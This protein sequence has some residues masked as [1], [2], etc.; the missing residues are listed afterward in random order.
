M[1]IGIG[2]INKE[3]EW[4]LSKVA[5]LFKYE[6]T[7]ELE[8]EFLK[9]SLITIIVYL[10][11][12][13]L[14][15]TSKQFK[16]HSNNIKRKENNELRERNGNETHGWRGKEKTHSFLS[17]L[18]A[19]ESQKFLPNISIIF[20]STLG[21]KSSEPSTPNSFKWNFKYSPR[22]L[23]IILFVS[24]TLE[25]KSNLSDTFRL[26]MHMAIFFQEHIHLWW[27]KAIES[28]RH[29]FIVFHHYKE[30]K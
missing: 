21:L 7:M 10:K 11:L 28:L 26:P 3:S 18:P 19:L 20:I 25:N 4:L 22:Q 23:F 29:I 13:L 27:S 17:S 8:L 6:L 15:L 30:N 9:K 14:H 2:I 5:S 12:I 1:G 16:I 24:T